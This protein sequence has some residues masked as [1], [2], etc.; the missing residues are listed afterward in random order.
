[1]DRTLYIT[2]LE[3]SVTVLF[4]YLLFLVLSP[5]LAAIV[6]AGAIGITIHPLYEKLLARCHERENAAAALMT[7]AVSLTMV[8]PLLG[9]V[10]V[11]GQI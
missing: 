9:L 8:V 2:L 5:F 6:W 3:C 11:A 1:M 10:F 7:T 4:M